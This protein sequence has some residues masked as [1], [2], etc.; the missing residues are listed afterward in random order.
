MKRQALLCPLSP[1]EARLSLEFR[2]LLACSLVPP[3]ALEASHE[4]AI[5]RLCETGPD[6]DRYLSLVDRHRVQGLAYSILERYAGDRVPAAIRTSLRERNRNIRIQALRH[7][8][9]LTRLTRR[10][11]DE[12]IDLMPLKG[13]TLSTYLYDDPGLR[14]SRDLDLMVRVEDL[15]RADKLL[16]SEGYERTF[17]DFEP[18]A[19]QKDLIGSTWQHYEYTHAGRTVALELHW[20]LDQW[21]PDQVVELWRCA[22]PPE[23]SGTQARGMDKG[24]LLALLCDHGA[25]HHWFR[26]KWLSD[27]SALLARCSGADGEHAMEAAERLD[28]LR[29]LGQAVLLVHWL[30]DLPVAEPFAA[31]IHRD[32]TAAVLARCAVKHILMSEEEYL[33]LSF[34]EKWKRKLYSMRLRCGVPRSHYLQTLFVDLEMW[35][36]FPL[37]DGICWLYYALRPLIWFRRHYL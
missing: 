10:F 3:E 20:R 21:T 31:L 23:G 4:A 32:G 28:L 13:T 37:P 7:A 8:A 18:T 35:R 24:M 9:E 5:H 29:P 26:V 34:G 36:R 27:V 1:D 33:H 25:H 12:N 6:W 14:Q 11:D 2:L 16:L 22:R 15:D 30:H 17:P 19:K